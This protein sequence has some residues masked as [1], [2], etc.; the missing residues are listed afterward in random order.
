MENSLTEE[1]I[2]IFND[3]TRENIIKQYFDEISEITSESKINYRSK[4]QNLF[5]LKSDTEEKENLTNVFK[6]LEFN[7]FD[8]TFNYENYANKFRCYLLQLHN[9]NF[10]FIVVAIP[11]FII[12]AL[13]CW[14]LGT[15][16]KSGK[17]SY[18]FPLAL[19]FI[20]SF[21]FLLTLFYAI[22][23]KKWHRSYNTQTYMNL[24]ASMTINPDN[25]SSIHSIYVEQAVKIS[26]FGSLTATVTG[27]YYCLYVIYRIH[28]G[29]C[30]AGCVDGLPLISLVGTIYIPFHYSVIMCIN[31]TATLIM[32]IIIL[33]SIIISYHLKYSTFPERISEYLHPISLWILFTISLYV[34]QY[35]RVNSFKNREILM[36]F[37][38]ER[39]KENLIETANIWQ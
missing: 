37:V 31:W 18:K 38:S 16:I 2:K 21:D 4:I 30:Y 3:N 39:Q 17:T 15:D 7:K 8:L 34:I 22:W 29:I 19:I 6:E 12:I 20:G 23:L 13:W 14:R 1:N 25:P 11:Q 35:S 27:V 10:F 5:N 26:K 9:P 32:Q 33:T 24:D 36:R 28:S